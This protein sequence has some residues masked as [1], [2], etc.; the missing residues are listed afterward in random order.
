MPSNSDLLNGS[1]IYSQKDR[2]TKSLRN[3]P[4]GSDQCNESSGTQEA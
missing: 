4:E 2:R 3:F 1:S